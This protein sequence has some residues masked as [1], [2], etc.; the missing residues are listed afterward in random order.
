MSCDT[1][2]PA[3][4]YSLTVD[5][6]SLLLTTVSK[7][8]SLVPTR[9]EFARRNNLYYSDDDEGLS[10]RDRYPLGTFPL[11][12][13]ASLTKYLPLVGSSKFD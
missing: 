5:P 1:P 12:E 13:A 2:G 11:L 6:K 10:D 8:T 9:I 4:A 7:P 3:S